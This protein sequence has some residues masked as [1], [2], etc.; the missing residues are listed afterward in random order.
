M[1]PVVAL[2]Q[3]FPLQAIAPLIIMVLGVGFLTK[4]VI[5]FLIAFFPLYNACVISL[6]TTPKPLL[7]KLSICRAPFTSGVFLVRLPASLPNI[8]AATK[9]GFTLA[10]LGAVVAEFIQPDKGLGYL[11]LIAQA[12]YDVE[13]IFI[14]VGMLMIQGV[15]VFSILTF[16]EARLV[17]ERSYA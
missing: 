14:A 15:T 7:A 6:Q 11:I 5:A 2:S 17:E 1:S 13:V 4:S 10:V 3:S 12:S 9:V 8:L 16:F